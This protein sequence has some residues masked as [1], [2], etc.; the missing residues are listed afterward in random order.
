MS[1]F[2]CLLVGLLLG[3]CV[4]GIL[5]CCIQINRVSYYEQELQKLRQKLND[6][7]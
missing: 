5:L 4:A 2:I 6:K 3:G 1:N 7:L